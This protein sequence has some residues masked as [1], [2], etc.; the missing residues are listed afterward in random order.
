METLEQAN[1]DLKKWI[2]NAKSKM[3]DFPREYR[4]GNENLEYLN[5]DTTQKTIEFS[6]NLVG[7][8]LCSDSN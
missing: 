5:T 2:P 1:S 6:E 4:R 7:V 8:S 3:F